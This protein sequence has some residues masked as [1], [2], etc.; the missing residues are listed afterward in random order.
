MIAIKRAY[1][2]PSRSDGSRILVDRLWPRGLKKEEAH[3]EKWIRELGP[4]NHLR[5]FFGHDPARWQEFR[6]RYLLELGRPE[7]AALLDELL[8]TARRGILTL[9]YSARDQEHNQAVVLKELL[10]RK[11]RMG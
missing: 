4:S 5:K 9:V 8:R 6:S 3:V 2:P 7:A 10:D 11:L 1:D